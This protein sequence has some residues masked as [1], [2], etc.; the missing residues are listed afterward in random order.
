MISE[1]YLKDNYLAKFY[2]LLLNK[3]IIEYDLKSANTSLCKEYDL[4]P[5]NIITK[6]ENKNKKD[7]Q[8]TIG[9]MMRKDKKLKEGIKLGFVDIRGRFFEANNIQDEEVLSIKKDA[10][11][12]LRE[13]DITDFGKCHFVKKNEYTS[14]MYLDTERQKL[15][16][17]Y[18]SIRENLEDD[19][20]LDIKGIND[21]ALE[22]H[23][24]YLMKFFI[25]L[26]RHLET[27]SEQVLY[28]YIK[29]FIHKYKNLGLEVGYYR[30]FNQSSIIH[31]INSPE[32][33]DDEVFIPYEHK[34]EHID[35]DFNFFY[36]LLPIL[37]IILSQ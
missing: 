18:S 7:R 2:K 37:K 20:K 32:E 23:E 11:F 25:I 30:E 1:L 31:L 12:C 15:E 22:K 14:Y 16:F 4:L 6:I 34:Q 27:S 9:K 35:I 13:M 17:Y 3:T 19:G 24:D 33:Y 10:I 29:R 36:I 26:F 21:I 5:D 28:S 8:V